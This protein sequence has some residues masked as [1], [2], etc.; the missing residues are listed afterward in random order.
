MNADRPP[1]AASPV[2]A[3][4]L[5]AAGFLLCGCQGGAEA[6]LRE[7]AAQ[8]L[9]AG[10]PAAWRRGLVTFRLAGGDPEAAAAGLAL[11]DLAAD[12]V[13]ARTVIHSLGQVTGA[14][15]PSLAAA[16]V[17]RVGR[18]GWQGV[19]VWSRA[20]RP[21]VAAVDEQVA[22]AR[23]AVLAA[24]GLPSETAV[25]AEPGA[26]L[27]DC[28]IDSP[29]RWWLG[30]HHAAGLPG[31][32]PGGS[33]PPAARPLPAGRVSRAWLKLD[34]AIAT[35]ELPLLR[36]QRAV[37]LG[38]APGGACQRLLEAGL[39]VVGVD[40][41]L[42]DSP[43]AGADGFT[44]W[45]MR[46]REVPLRRFKGTDWLVADMNIDPRS[47]LEALGRVA[48]AEDVRLKGIIATLKIPHWSRAA[49]L[50]AWLD[51]FRGWGFQPRGRQLSSGGREICVVALRAPVRH[52]S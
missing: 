24:C 51:A 40:P 30:W 9:P 21:G 27:L 2:P 11:D 16:V 8:V 1:P 44:Q 39:R 35:F 26:R 41:A 18:S 33:Y 14:D 19:H 31:R 10:R 15:N 3:G 34:E 49:E 29:N 20:G 32:W 28:V 6:A 22:A 25:V 38:A 23:A 17:E 45:R 4:L 7:R 50:P 37:E 46:A 43:V 52:R 12:L 5:P 48:T 13:F 47:T 42:I 36:G